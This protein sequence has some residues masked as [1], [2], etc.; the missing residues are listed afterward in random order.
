MSDRAVLIAGKIPPR[1]PNPAIR[2]VL[3]LLAL[4]LSFGCA[5]PLW[6]GDPAPS[7]A[8]VKAAFLLNFPKYVQWPET[9]FSETNGPIIVAILN[10]DDIADEFATMSEGRTI[11]GHRIRLQRVSSLEQC[12]G[13]HILFFGSAQTRKLPEVLPKLRGENILTVGESDDFLDAGGMIN[14]GRRGRQITLEVNIDSVHQTGLKV[15]SKLLALATVKG[16]K[17]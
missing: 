11:D 15:S 2:A 1:K 5:F 7:E 6:A 10:A 8:Q 17:K 13:C 16:G 12:H 3:V 14:L 4:M 9:N